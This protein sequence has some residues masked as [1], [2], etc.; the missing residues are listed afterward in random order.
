MFVRSNKNILLSLLLLILLTL[1]FGFI[2]NDEYYT[3][4]ST[5]GKGILIFD[6][7]ALPL[8]IRDITK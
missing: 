3:I 1:S 7:L 8:I 5:L 2:T 6:L 4:L